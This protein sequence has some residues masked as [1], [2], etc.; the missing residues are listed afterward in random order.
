MPE[1][2]NRIQEIIEKKQR[3]YAENI[4][5]KN[6]LKLIADESKQQSLV[7]FVDEYVNYKFSAE[8]TRQE[9][10]KKMKE[11]FLKQMSLHQFMNPNCISAF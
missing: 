7:N 10:K 6:C 11:E 9:M 2:N 4:L 1:L 3:E 5:G 8:D